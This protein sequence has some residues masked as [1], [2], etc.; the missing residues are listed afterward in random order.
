MSEQMQDTERAA[1]D[2]RCVTYFAA[3]VLLKAREAVDGGFGFNEEDVFDAAKR[4]GLVTE[5]ERVTPCDPENCTC[6]D[7]LGSGEAT[8]C[9]PFTDIGQAVIAAMRASEDAAAKGVR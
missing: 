8:T 1:F 3:E 9:Y 2:Q 6:A 7:L 4:F 5:V